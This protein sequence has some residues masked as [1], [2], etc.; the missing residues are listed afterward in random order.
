MSDKP[1]EMTSRI[2]MG[3]SWYGQDNIQRGDTLMVPKGEA[4]WI[5][6]QGLADYG[7]VPVE[8]LRPGYEQD[9]EDI[10]TA[11]Q[12]AREDRERWV[13]DHPELQPRPNTSPIGARYVSKFHP[14]RQGWG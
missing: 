7:R 2:T 8:D 1:V 4:K 14:S 6:A 11:Q 12:L 10:A 5:H 13:R 9:E 3:G